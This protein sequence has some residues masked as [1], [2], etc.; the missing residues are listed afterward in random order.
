MTDSPKVRIFTCT[1]KGTLNNAWNSIIQK[2][3]ANWTKFLIQIMDSAR[4]EF[5][6]NIQIQ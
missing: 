5:A 6:A 2:E 1:I 4:S 3:S